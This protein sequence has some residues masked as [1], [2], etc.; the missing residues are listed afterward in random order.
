MN[1]TEFLATQLPYGLKCVI[2]K[3]FLE[4]V[5]T[6]DAGAYYSEFVK[7]GLKSIPIIRPLDSLVKECVQ[8]DYNGGKPFVP[9]LELIKLEEKYNKWKDPAP[10]IPYD[11]EIIQK[12]FGKVLKVSKLGEWVVYLSLSEM[13]RAKWYVIQ[14]LLKWHFW[15]NMPEG[16]EVIW[17]TSEFNPY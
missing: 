17:V 4:S 10:T 16:E 1:K 12:P 2:A 8:A 7:N 9:A 13:E 5:F 15:P 3:N 14:Q 6:Y 11:I